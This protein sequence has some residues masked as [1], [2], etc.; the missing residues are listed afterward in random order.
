MNELEKKLRRKELLEK[1]LALKN[2]LP[3][4]HG[5]KFYKWSREFFESRN[6]NQFLVAANQISKSS[7]LIRKV[8]HWATEDSLWPELW[9]HRRPYQFWYF[10]PS[11]EVMRVEVEKK[12]VP[13]F[14]P[15]GEFKDDPKYGWDIQYDKGLP[16]ALH[17][18]SG[19]SVYFK[20]YSQKASDLQTGTVDMM[21]LDEELP[22]EL[23]DELNQRRSAT[24]GYIC[25]VFT[26]TL[27]QE[28]WRKVMEVRGPE[29]KFPDAFK[30][31][32][33]KFDC[34]EYEDGSKT[35][36]T[37]ERINRE[38]H[39]CKSE[40]EVARRIKGRFVKETGLK[41]A[42]FDS[43]KNVGPVPVP[44][45]PANWIHVAGVDC[46]GGG[47]GHPGAVAIISVAPD[48]KK[49]RVT[50]GWRG[51][52][53]LTSSSDI[54]SKYLDVASGLTISQKY[55]DWAAK[56]FQI[57]TSRLGDSFLPAE[58]GHDIGESTLNTLFKN[59]MLTID[60][61]P[62]LAPLVTEFLTLSKETPK[63][64]AKDDYTDAVRYG[65][66]KLP[67]DWTDIKFDEI[68]KSKLPQAPPREITVDELRMS[69]HS[70]QK[71]GY[72]TIEEELEA[73]NEL[74]EADI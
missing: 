55:Y 6:K 44:P 14:L 2:G 19:V 61:S 18:K 58:K 56:E 47:E 27:G 34:L 21:G 30:L 41:Y 52:G 25:N 64:K 5:F 12:W 50:R 9:P 29:E 22:E 46:G 32:V 7:T 71:D 68:E 65:V 20:S 48:F 1:K 59:G 8:I 17:F 42:H 60:N 63:N 36:W 49:G 51:E 74:Y 37:V 3:H 38:I 28:F 53:E 66:T 13:E 54:Y 24:D 26:A 31:Q 72:D 70:P 69:V 11:K 62:E 43:T 35:P 67:W 39:Q 57:F 33:S 23:W 15:R 73:W 10:Y 45:I 4:L 16:L 40:A